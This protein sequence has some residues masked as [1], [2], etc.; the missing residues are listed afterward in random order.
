MKRVKTCFLC[1]KKP[2]KKHPLG[3]TARLSPIIPRAPARESAINRI[4][5]QNAGRREGQPIVHFQVCISIS[6]NNTNINK[7]LNVLY[8]TKYNT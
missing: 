4:F 7:I 8:T 2:A 3:D 1:Q 6:I 5:D